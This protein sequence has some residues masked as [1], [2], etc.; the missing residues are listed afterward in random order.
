[1]FL[2]S[3]FAAFVLGLL[4]ASFFAE[5][6][7]H[8]HLF[9]GRGW[10]RLKLM[11]HPAIQEHKRHHLENFWAPFWIKFGIIVPLLFGLSLLFS[12]PLFSSAGFSWGVT[13]YYILVE[14]GHWSLHNVEPSTRFGLYLRKWHFHH[15]FNDATSNF[16]FFALFYDV[17]FST[18]TSPSMIKV[19]SSYEVPWLH[20]GKQI[21]RKYRADFQLR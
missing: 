3:F 11:W 6:L 8:R 1:M 2:A 7:L 18:Y 9:H 21:F 16:S 12:W 4:W 17:L 13:L 19:P 15:H 14:L 20:D 10:L 5:F